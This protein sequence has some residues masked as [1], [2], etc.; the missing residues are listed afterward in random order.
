MSY[1]HL[2]EQERYVINHLRIAGFTKREIGRKINHH[3]STI[4]RELKR[5]GTGPRPNYLFYYWY[6][7][8]HRIALKRRLKSRHRRRQTNKRLVRYVESK[9]KVQWSPEE[10]AQR[11]RRDY[12]DDERMRISHETIYRWIYMDASLGGK[13]YLNL[14]RLR[15]KRRKQKRYG[16]GRRFLAG[17][18]NIA[19]RP[20][21]VNGRQRFGDWEGD[22]VEG[23]K[24]S[25]Y[26]ATLVERK[27]RYLLAYI[28]PTKK[29]IKLTEQGVKAFRPIP[30]R[31]RH[32]LTVDNGSEFARFKEFEKKAGLDIYFADPYSPWQRGANENTNGLLRQYFP[33]GSDFKKVAEEEITEAVKRLNNRP[34]KCLNYQTPHEVFWQAASGA[35]AI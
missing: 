19:E 13:A 3:H 35:L 33:K 28:L 23:K 18:K 9:L 22:T 30:R 1:T 27:S 31:M 26:I 12:P 2:S 32:T 25:G 34:R 21:I 7:E 4:S 14:R 5:N 17:R 8:T 29:A 16:T 10:I 6:V 24:S 20:Q 11:I 15:M